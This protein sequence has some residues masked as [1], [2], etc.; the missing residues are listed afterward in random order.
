MRA[1]GCGKAGT[2]TKVSLCLKDAATFHVIAQ[3]SGANHG[4]VIFVGNRDC[5]LWRRL[6]R[7]RGL[8]S[9]QLAEN[10]AEK[11]GARHRTLIE[12]INPPWKTRQKN[13]MLKYVSL[14][15]GGSK[16]AYQPRESIGISG[17]PS[18]RMT[19]FFV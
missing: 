10:Q 1:S 18:L 4:G 17:P 16:N 13:R 8:R 7:A 9:R 2:P 14:T 5:D 12:K 6:R 3:D 11:N 15:R 19:I